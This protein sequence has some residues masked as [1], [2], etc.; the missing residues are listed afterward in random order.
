MLPFFIWSKA[1]D[2][3]WRF[4]ACVISAAILEVA[5]AQ[6]AKARINERI[7]AKQ[8]LVIAED[9]EQLGIKEIHD[10]LSIAKEQELDLV[11]VAGQADPPVCRIMDYG[12]FKYEQTQKAKRSKKHQQIIVV[13]EMK[14]RPKIEEH[15]F[16]TKEKH[17]RRFLNAGAKVKITIMFRGRETTH[18]D[19]GRGILERLAEEVSDLGSIEARP[20][21]D[22]RN[23]T[24]VL[25][26]LPEILASLRK[27]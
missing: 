19:I 8:V 1:V 16:K 4:R 26:P 15:D 22:G 10:A 6:I 23:M 2:Y 11:E 27:E 17:V 20:K 18:P 14:F 7:R 13:K 12:K 24:M 9:G 5:L 25:A 3:D 21:L